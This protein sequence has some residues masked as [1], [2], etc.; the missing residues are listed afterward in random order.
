MALLMEFGYLPGGFR[1]Y[2]RQP[3]EITVEGEIINAL[4]RSKV[5]S[6]QK[7]ARIKGSSRT[8]RGVGAFQNYAMVETDLAPDVVLQ[9][10]TGM[11]RNIVFFSAAMVPGDINIRHA[12]FREYVFYLLPEKVGDVQLFSRAIKLFQGTHYFYAF[13][14]TDRSKSFDMSKTKHTIDEITLETREL[15]TKFTAL[16]GSSLL[17]KTNSP[18]QILEVRFRARYFLYQQIR[19][20]VGA[21]VRVARGNATI[22]D[23][24][25]ALNSSSGDK[26]APH[27]SSGL[28]LE[29]VELLPFRQVDKV[30]YFKDRRPIHDR[31]R[32][33]IL[34]SLVLEDLRD[35]LH[36]NR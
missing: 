18:K 36:Y 24:K 27:S 30:E 25:D 8:D 12:R 15:E 32:R 22:P 20:M 11:C 16:D 3:G 33:F 28:F 4:V 10:L 23:L 35:S 1:G 9:R 31:F 19:R 7:S 21:A 26:F 5:V 29:C 34:C 13:I 17:S 14:K 6:D 2:A